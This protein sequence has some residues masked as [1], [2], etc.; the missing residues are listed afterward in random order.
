M[1]KIL[2]I[3]AVAGVMVACN[4]ATEEETTTTDT[5][6][7]TTTV[8]TVDD[9]LQVGPADTTVVVGDTTSAQ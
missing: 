2:G 4:N 7:T 8:P 9:T 1:K 6:T 3:I 5:T